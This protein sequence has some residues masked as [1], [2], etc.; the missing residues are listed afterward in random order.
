MLETI[1]SLIIQ[2]LSQHSTG[3]YIAGAIGVILMGI[4]KSGFGAGIGFLAVPLVASQ[5]NVNVALALMLPILMVIDL[6]GV[7]IFLKRFDRQIMKSILPMGLLGVILGILFFKQISPK[8][9]SL[10]IGIFTILFLVHR[11]ILSNIPQLAQ[12]KA[13]PFFGKAMAITSGFTS[14]IAHNGGPPMT[15]FMLSQKL[16]ALAYTATLGVFFTAINLS[17]W[18]P[19]GFLGLLNWG[20]VVASL[21]LMPLV[22]IGVYLGFYAAKHIPQKTYYKL[23]Y[24]CMLGAGIKMLWDGLR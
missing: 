6:V 18:V 12:N 3:F 9:L 14:F 7:G 11:L 1:Y 16:D 10:S 2:A 22:P 17:K 13:S 8:T 21:V 4:S 24:L 19:Y 15:A 20:E 23:V 5:S